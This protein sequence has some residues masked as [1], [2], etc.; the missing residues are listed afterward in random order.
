LP[1][2]PQQPRESK[3]EDPHREPEP[4]T[5]LV[6]AATALSFTT[7]LIQVQ[8]TYHGHASDLL[9]V[10]IAALLALAGMAR[11]SLRAAAHKLQLVT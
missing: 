1:V 11:K 5:W 6:P 3:P 7:I 4:A 8:A 9:P 10:L 2:F